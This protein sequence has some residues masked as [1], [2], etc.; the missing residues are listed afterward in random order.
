MGPEVAKARGTASFRAI[1]QRMKCSRCG[2]RGAADCAEPAGAA[3]KPEGL[4]EIALP[5]L[6]TLPSDASRE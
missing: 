1:R 3:V 5:T 6:R 4:L 2:Q